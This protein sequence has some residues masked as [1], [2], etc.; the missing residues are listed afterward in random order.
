M[1]VGPQIP[2]RAQGHQVAKA[3]LAGAD[4]GQALVA[5]LQQGHRPE[6]VS[7]GGPQANALLQALLQAGIPGDAAG[8][9]PLQGQLFSAAGDGIHL[10]LGSP[11]E[12]AQDLQRLL[13]ARKAQS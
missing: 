12:G 13:Q 8:E 1:Q 5:G 3:R 9:V 6:E 10:S 4:Q 2:G 11:S 7:V